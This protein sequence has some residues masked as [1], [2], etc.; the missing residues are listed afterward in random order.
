MAMKEKIFSMIKS[1]CLVIGYYTS[2]LWPREKRLWCFTEGE[3]SFYL[4][5]ELSKRRN[6]LDCH[7]LVNNKEK[8]KLLSIDYD[9]VHYIYSWKGILCQIKASVIF[10]THTMPSKISLCIMGGAAKFNLWHGIGIK[11]MGALNRIPSEDVWF[12]I[13]SWHKYIDWRYLSASPDILL[14]TSIETRKWLSLCFNISENKV[15][16]ASYPRVDYIKSTKLACFLQSAYAH[17]VRKIID[18]IHKYKKRFMYMPT[19]RESNPNYFDNLNFD[20][21]L[22]NDKMKSI[23]SIFI[24]KFHPYTKMKIEGEYENIMVIDSSVDVYPFLDKIDLLITDYSSIYYEYILLGDKEI[25]L[26]PFDEIEYKNNQRGLYFDYDSDMS[27]KRVY[28]F[29]EL[30]DSIKLESMYKV[31]NRERLILKFW[32]NQEKLTN[33]L[34]K[35]AYDLN[36][37]KRNLLTNV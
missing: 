18:N 12:K 15:I 14:A 24:F 11:N 16:M 33:I 22:L 36:I 10:L 5:L 3:N 26:F 4:F 31:P 21:S 27:G 34:E 17:Q 8:A 6:N 30:Y 23:D 25:I 19:W 28:S 20:L 7:L 9:N 13:N 1:F 35:S 29:N 32:G 37:I 2:K